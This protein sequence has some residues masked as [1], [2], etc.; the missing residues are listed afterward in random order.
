VNYPWI[1]IGMATWLGVLTSVS[2][3]PLA[4]NIAAISFVGR[5][6]GKT[7][8]VLLSGFLYTL[9]RSLTYIAVAVIVIKGFLGIPKV[10]NFLQQYMSLIL[11]PLILLTGVILLDIIRIGFG[12]GIAASMQS[13][14][15]RAGLLGSLLLGIV[16]A[17]TFCPVSAAL[18][19]G[20]L[21]PLAI[22]HQTHVMMPLLYG[23]GTAIPVI[24][25][26][27]LLTASAK[28]VSSIF[29]KITSVELWARRI[30]AFVFILAGLYMIITNNL[31]LYLGF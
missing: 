29:N 5:R 9:G 21:V 26:A 2:P 31:G 4:T 28:L 22:K 17:L 10:S 15:E 1:D 18:F 27:I 3:C 30:T 16:F 8:Q 13:R 25:F 20:G 23:I 7:R 12:G 14:V 11:G 6:V 24:G 19:F